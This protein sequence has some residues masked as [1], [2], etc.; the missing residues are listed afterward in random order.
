[1]TAPASSTLSYRQIGEALGIS[2]QAVGALVAKGMPIGSVDEARRWRET[3]LDVSRTKHARVAV[4]PVQA[5]SAP[6]PSASVL[7]SSDQIRVPDDKDTEPAPDDTQE[8]RQARTEREQIR[9]DRERLELEQLQGRLLDVE[10]ARRLAFTAFRQLRDGVL[11]VPARVA[12]QVAVMT[13]ALQI[14]QLIE[15][16]LNEAFGRF[17]PAK[18]LTDRTDEDEAD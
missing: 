15:A 8:Y 7:A 2:K 17:D 18:L 6:S 14:E 1:L 5:A 12:P 3:N 4:D 13:D 9:R 10:E 16:Q 11:N